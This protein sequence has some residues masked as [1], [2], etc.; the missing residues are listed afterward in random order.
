MTLRSKAPAS[1]PRLLL[2]STSGERGGA[3]E[4]VLAI[5]REARRRG[6][7]TF[8]GVPRTLG[9]SSLGDDLRDAGA[10]VLPWMTEERL[11]KTRVAIAGLAASQALA[12][13]RLIR[14]AR[15]SV[16]LYS[17]QHSRAAIGS[18]LASSWMRCP[19]MVTFQ[20][21]PEVP[22]RGTLRARLWAH[23]LTR[24]DRQLRTLVAVSRQNRENVAAA[25]GMPEEGIRL[26]H[27]GARPP[28]SPMRA[29]PPL[30]DELGL[31]AH[32]RLVTT[33]ARLHRDKGYLDLLE[34][35]PQIVRAV[36][37]A[38]FVWVGDG[39]LRLELRDRIEAQSLGSVVKL[40]GQRSDVPRILA[41]SDVFALPTYYEGFSFA[42]LEAMQAGLPI[43]TTDAPGVAEL[44]TSG[45]NGLTSSPGDH[46]GLRDAIAQILEDR[47]LRSRLA[48][49]GR[50]SASAY[51][52]ARMLEQ[53]FDSLSNLASRA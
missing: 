37:E 17:L 18:L 8:A 46:A 2:L 25:L 10:Q 35:V 27:N 7:G 53:T 16:T 45:E 9:N 19:R 50:V 23:A 38:R 32:S 49:A 29:T 1:R 4:Y 39:P 52:E 3:E 24:G 42:L 21:F 6:W 48:A 34:V 31:P 14:R 33:V 40:L 28:A 5:A 44:V 20:L 12:T 11:P 30:R 13:W 36:P 15:P 22:E 51:S 41:E 43:I 26:I 47:A